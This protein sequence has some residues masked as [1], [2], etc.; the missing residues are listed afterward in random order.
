QR[1]TLV[2]IEAVGNDEQRE[3][4]QRHLEADQAT[5][6]DHRCSECASRD[7]YPTF[8]AVVHRLI[9]YSVEI[10]RRPLLLTARLTTRSL[11]GH[12]L[13]LG[14]LTKLRLDQWRSANDPKLHRLNVRCLDL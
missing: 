3:L 11:G 4:R 6:R 12:H 1:R 14:L 5:R 8:T 7:S 10:L 13:F 9:A 2:A